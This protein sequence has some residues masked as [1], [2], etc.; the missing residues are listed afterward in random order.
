MSEMDEA[1]IQAKVAELMADPA[2]AARVQ[3]LVDR[4]TNDPEF[5]GMD[6]PAAIAAATARGRLLGWQ[7]MRELGYD[8]ET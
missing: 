8:V 4:L 7:I 3:E 6:G 5:A 1:E 2:V